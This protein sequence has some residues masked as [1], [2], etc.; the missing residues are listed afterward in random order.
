MSKKIKISR[1]TGEYESQFRFTP[2]ADNGRILS[3]RDYYRNKYDLLKMLK[4]YFKDWEIVDETVKQVRPMKIKK[5]TKEF[6][7]AINKKP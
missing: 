4:K 7:N 5:T 2:V 1:G 6:L 3:D